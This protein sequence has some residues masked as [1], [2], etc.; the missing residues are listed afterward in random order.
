MR[1]QTIE[2]FQKALPCEDL[3]QQQVRGIWSGS[4]SRSEIVFSQRWQTDR[5]IRCLVWAFSL[6]Y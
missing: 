2:G 5:H 1:S 4:K 6:H 3:G